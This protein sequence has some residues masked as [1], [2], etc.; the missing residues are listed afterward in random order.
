MHELYVHVVGHMKMW[1]IMWFKMLDDFSIVF[2]IEFAMIFG[3]VSD[4]WKPF[5]F[6]FIKLHAWTQNWCIR[7]NRL[8]MYKLRLKISGKG[9]RN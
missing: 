1:M 5:T 6:D 9:E 3:D 4:F 8:N 7:D 2:L